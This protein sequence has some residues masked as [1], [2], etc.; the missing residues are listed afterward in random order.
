MINDETKAKLAN[1]VEETYQKLEQ[2]FKQQLPRCKGNFGVKSS[3]IA[4][5]AKYST[6]EIQINVE[7]L[8]QHEEHVLHVTVPHEICHLVAAILWPNMKQHHGWE[9]KTCMKVVGLRPDTYH[10]LGRINKPDIS[11]FI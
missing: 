1:K 5:I 11:E 3:R 10:Q 2:H 7:Y 6:N 8:K 4:G 9:W